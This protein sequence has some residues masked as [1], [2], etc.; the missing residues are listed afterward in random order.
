M[1]GKENPNGVNLPLSPPEEYSCYYK[2][3]MFIF[4]WNLFLD[5]QKPK[6]SNKIANF[7]HN[8]I[9]STLKKNSITMKIRKPS[10]PQHLLS[11][12]R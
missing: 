7:H 1:G 10:T 2:Q 6:K 4:N 12:C 3:N 5:S 8:I 9:K 11:L